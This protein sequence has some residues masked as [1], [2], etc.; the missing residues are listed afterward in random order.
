MQ[1][2]RAYPK[3][4]LILQDLPG[5]IQQVKNDIWPS[6]CPEAIAEN[7][8]QFEPMDFF[9]GPPILGCNIYYVR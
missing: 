2:A 4:Q 5:C 8:I 7:R 6:Q 3:L 9:A 1:L